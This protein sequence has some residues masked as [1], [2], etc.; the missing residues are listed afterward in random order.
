MEKGI[1]KKSEAAADIRATSF[2]PSLARP[3]REKTKHNKVQ[4]KP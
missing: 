2:S 3:D 4:Q 1:K